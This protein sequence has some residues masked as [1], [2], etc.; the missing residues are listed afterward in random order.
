MGYAEWAPHGTRSP[1]LLTVISLP[2]AA[3]KHALHNPF[4]AITPCKVD[5]NSQN[6][7]KWRLQKQLLPAHS[8]QQV[9]FRTSC[10]CACSVCC[11]NLR[12][13]DLPMPFVRYRITP[14]HPVFVNRMQAAFIA[15]MNHQYRWN[16]A[17]IPID[18]P[19]IAA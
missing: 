17:S 2:R 13:L 4:A 5:G 11:C 16:K 6:A 9:C 15:I 7:Q 3:R 8:L 10:Y 19:I 14:L 12:P 1:S 18:R